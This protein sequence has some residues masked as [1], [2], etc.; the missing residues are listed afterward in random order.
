MCNPCNTCA[1]FIVP[2]VSRLAAMMGVPSQP[3]AG[4]AL[5]KRW[6]RCKS[7]LPRLGATDLLGR[8]NTSSKSSL[9]SVSTLMSVSPHQVQNHRHAL[10]FRFADHRIASFHYFRLDDA[11]ILPQVRD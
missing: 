10:S 11:A 1:I 7:T 4:E 9:S 3:A 8:I 6:L 5:R 2:T